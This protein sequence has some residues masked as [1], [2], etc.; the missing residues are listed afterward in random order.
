M[1]VCGNIEILFILADNNAGTAS[2]RF[3]LHLSEKE[4][5]NL[6]PCN[7]RN[8]YDGRHCLLNNLRYVRYGPAHIRIAHIRAA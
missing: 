5:R 8:G 1:V 2:F 7:R 6:R 4:I 3:F